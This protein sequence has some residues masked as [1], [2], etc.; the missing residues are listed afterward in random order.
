MDVSY[1]SELLFSNLKLTSF[2]EV[3]AH[4]E[5]KE[6]MQ[7]EYYALIKNGIWR[8]V[9]PPFGTKLIFVSGYTSK[10]TY[11]MVDSTSIR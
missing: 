10:S 3:V 5:W 6:S 9:S 2:E 7:N 4:N 11:H 8:L 1:D